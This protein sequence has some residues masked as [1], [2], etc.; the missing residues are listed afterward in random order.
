MRADSRSLMRSPRAV[1]SWLALLVFAAAMVSKFPFAELPQ[2]IVN[3]GRLLASH[4]T[5]RVDATPFWFDPQYAAFIEAVR[6]RTPRD[7]TVAL[8]VPKTI[9][10]YVYCAAYELAPRKI[11]G[12]EEAEHARHVAVY[13]Q[14]P[15]PDLPAGEPIPGGRLILR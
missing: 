15:R 1:A 10:L 6:E 12:E 11:V 9:D 2:R 7:A 8:V 4:Q 13:G 14:T 3:A 5:V